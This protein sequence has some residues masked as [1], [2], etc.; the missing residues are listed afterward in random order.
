[1]PAG[2]RRASAGTL[3]QLLATGEGLAHV[4]E[5]RR[6]F[7]FLTVR[8]NLLL[9]AHNPTARP[10]RAEIL[11]ALER[12]FPVIA[13]R[14]AQLANTLVVLAAH[15]APAAAGAEGLVP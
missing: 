3:A 5:R 8:D 11:D 4:L 1:M 12:L 13:A 6:L 15:G 2:T 7:P 14:S 9:G 10:H